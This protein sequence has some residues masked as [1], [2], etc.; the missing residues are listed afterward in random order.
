M[1]VGDDPQGRARQ[2]VKSMKTILLATAA[3]VLMSGT[4]RAAAMTCEQF[5]ADLIKSSRAVTGK[6]VRYRPGDDPGFTKV[7]FVPAVDM[8][9]ACEGDNFDQFTAVSDAWI[10]K[11]AESRTRWMNY[12]MEFAIRAAGFSDTET[13][14]VRRRL[15]TEAASNEGIVMAEITVK[16]WYLQFDMTKL[17]VAFRMRPPVN[18]AKA[19]AQLTAAKAEWSQKLTSLPYTITSH[20]VGFK[21]VYGVCRHAGK[22]AKGENT[23]NQ[24]DWRDWSDSHNVPYHWFSDSKACEDAQLSIDTKHPADVK[25]NPDDGF[26]SDCMPASKVSGHTAVKGYKMV[27]AL[28]APGAG[29]MDERLWADLRESASRTPRVFKTFNACDDAVD[30][31]YSKTLKDLGADE[32]GNLLRDKTEHIRLTAT[33]VR[34]Y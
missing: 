22:N 2:K 29:P 9:V 5:L 20:D 27:F 33:C 19:N 34:V 3:I 23:C 31:T 26:M 18:D 1:S 24:D 6:P 30:A 7:D 28:S 13:A 21:L 12:S 4:A 14:A 17:H 10:E 32:D 16:D 25:V 8:S 11:D 15:A